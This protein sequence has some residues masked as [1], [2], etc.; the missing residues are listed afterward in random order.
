MKPNLFQLATK[1]LAQDGFLVWLLQWA[2]ESNKQYDPQLNECAAF[3]AK[4]LLQKQ[5]PA[6]VEIHTVTAGRKGLLKNVDV[7]AVINQQ[8]LLVI[9][10]KTVTERHSNQLAIYKKEAEALCAAKNWKPVYIY[11]KT[12]SESQASLREIEQQEGYHCVTRAELLGWLGKFQVRNPIFTDFYDYLCQQEMAEQAFETRPLDQWDA[13]CWRGFYQFLETQLPEEVSSWRYVANRAGGFWGCWF[14]SRA[15]NGYQIYLQVEQA[16]LCIKLEIPSDSPQR[17]KCSRESWQNILKLKAEK[18]LPEIIKP[19]KLS[20]KGT[21]RTVALIRAEDWLRKPGEVL[22]KQQ[23][24]ENI[25]KY[26]SFIRE[27]ARRTDDK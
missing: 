1:E 5:V 7:W 17:D 6:A 13:A 19:Q 3:F 11:L 24:V 26:L 15:C 8:Y 20:N 9:E 18:Q 27:Y 4:M 16:K 25:K 14:H 2:D 22:N 21:W 12:G 23:V 10:D